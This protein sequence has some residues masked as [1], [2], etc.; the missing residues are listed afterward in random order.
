MSS[1]SETYRIDLLGFPGA[2]PEEAAEALSNAFGI[3][4]DLAIA[5]VADAPVTVR[6][7]I[8]GTTAR[9]YTHA[10]LRVGASV[11]VV[12]EATGREREFTMRDLEAVG[13]GDIAATSAPTPAPAASPRTGA[14]REVG[15]PQAA[16]VRL[17]TC[18][19]CGHRQAPSPRCDNCGYDFPSGP[20]PR[21]S[22][23]ETDRAP[24]GED[25][26]VFETLRTSAE[27]AAVRDAAARRR[28]RAARRA[29][30]H[31]GKLVT[32]KRLIIYGVLGILAGLTFLLWVLSPTSDRDDAD[33]LPPGAIAA[34]PGFEFRHDR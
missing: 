33:P 20:P 23:S 5:Y 12:A 19:A 27:L 25:V 7:S 24:A 17:R 2:T 31:E 14:A 1:P 22:S 34:P 30:A 21:A 15:R 6:T 8:D 28:A 3:E 26:D 10:L 11:R 18:P 13:T 16:E 9:D 32:R 29:A 4:T